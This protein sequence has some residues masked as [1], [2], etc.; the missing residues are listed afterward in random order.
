ME[1]LFELPVLAFIVLRAAARRKQRGTIQQL[2]KRDLC[3]LMGQ[4]AG[5][6]W[7]LGESWLDRI[8]KGQIDR[9]MDALELL[10]RMRPTVI[11]SWIPGGGNA[12]VVNESGRNVF[13]SL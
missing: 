6:R 11:G 3:V 1:A 2:H 13:R 9:R 12:M 10:I 7:W 8:V 5:M 4:L